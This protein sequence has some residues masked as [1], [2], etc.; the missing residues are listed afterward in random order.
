MHNTDHDASTTTPAADR[1]SRRRKRS[2]AV[3]GL[4]VVLGGGAIAATQWTGNDDPAVPVE[5]AA[6]ATAAS[7]STDGP[8]DATASPS[9]SEGS[10]PAHTPASPS[11]KSPEPSP[12]LPKDAAQRIAEARAAAAKE[13]V[14][15]KPAIPAPTSPELPDEAIT[16][17][18]S[19]SLQKDKA[20]MRLV[21][22]RGDLTGQRELAM[23]AD[24]GE[25]FGNSRCSQTI[26]VVNEAKP[27]RK[28]TLLICWRTSAKKSVYTVAVDL[29]G[30]P[31]EQKSVAAIDTEWK[32]LG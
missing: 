9:P 8:V 14:P 17:R 19:G 12:S 18:D 11:S 6:P 4:A 15:V 26:S 3:A 29:D 21:S 22:A 28:P 20:T 23:V 27:Q 7:D 10:A 2:L 1:M 32:R 30:D 13:G 5:L 24:D 16:V 31:S 25:K